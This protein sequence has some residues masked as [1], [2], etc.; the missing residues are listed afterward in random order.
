MV[1]TREHTISMDEDF[2]LNLARKMIFVRI[3]RVPCVIPYGATTDL[4]KVCDGN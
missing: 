4:I 3:F 2:F 1:Y